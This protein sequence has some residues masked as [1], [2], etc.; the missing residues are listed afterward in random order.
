LQAREPRGTLIRCR[1]LFVGHG[2]RVLL[3]PLDLQLG[4]GELWAILGR[5]GSGKTTLFRTLLGLLPPVGGVIERAPN[6]T[7]SYVPQRANLDP[8][9]PALARDVVVMGTERGWSFLGGPGD[10][11]ARATKSLERA[12]AA[13]LAEHPFRSLSEGQKQRVLLARVIAARPQLA[14]MDEPTSAMDE[15]AER[16]T[17]QHLDWLRREHGTTVL[18]VSHQLG[19]LRAVADHALLLDASCGEV[20]VGKID[21][22]MAH[23]VFTHAYGQLSPSTPAHG[24]PR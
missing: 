3:P 7:M 15:V 18:V 4:A 14:L 8:I 17:L 13:H 24:A 21:E 16:E 2:G 23:P 22:V 9:Y 5:N 1:R 20:V 6:M 10:A 12:G 19:A 11:R